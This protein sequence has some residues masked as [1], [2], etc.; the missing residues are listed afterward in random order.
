MAKL[1]AHPSPA[2]ARSLLNGI[3]RRR[4]LDGGLNQAIEH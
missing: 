3:T 1:Q 4:T 2:Q